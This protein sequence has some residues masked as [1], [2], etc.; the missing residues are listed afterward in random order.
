MQALKKKTLVS[1]V[2]KWHDFYWLLL[3]WLLTRTLQS[4]LFKRAMAEDMS[5]EQIARRKFS[6]WLQEKN[7]LQ[8]SDLTIRENE[9][10]EVST[11]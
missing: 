2:G 8:E 9:P 6:Q 11:I 1:E 3:W 4:T 5:P 7:Y 10:F